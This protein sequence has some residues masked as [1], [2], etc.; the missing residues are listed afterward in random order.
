MLDVRTEDTADRTTSPTL[1][2]GLIRSA[3]AS[4]LDASLRNLD[5]GLALR[6][7]NHRYSSSHL[8][9]HV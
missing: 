5:V 3:I 8:N 9:V 7:K 6:L 4:R 2:L 1:L